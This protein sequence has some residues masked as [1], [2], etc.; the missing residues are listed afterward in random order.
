MTSNVTFKN[1]NT[2]NGVEKSSEISP[3][4][5]IISIKNYEAALEAA[6]C[7][8]HNPT[9]LVTTVTQL[10]ALWLDKNEERSSYVQARSMQIKLATAWGLHLC[11]AN[12]IVWIAQCVLFQF[13]SARH[14]HSVMTQ[15]LT[16]AQ[17][18]KMK[19]T[20]WKVCKQDMRDTQNALFCT[21]SALEILS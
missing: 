3:D 14:L 1:T 8:Y 15:W 7:T 18:Y 4:V 11:G 19:Q 17:C 21:R 2:H 5:Q 9:T 16:I 10:G 13:L 6:I 20:V 12:T